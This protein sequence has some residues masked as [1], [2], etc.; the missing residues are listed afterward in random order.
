[1]CIRDRYVTMIPTVWPIERYKSRKRKSVMD[2]QGIAADSVD[3]WTKS[4]IQRY[5]E[6]PGNLEGINLAQFAAWYAPSNLKRRAGNKDIE[7]DEEDGE[8]DTCDDIVAKYRRRDVCRV[9]RF[10]NYDIGDLNNFKREMVT[11]YLPFRNEVRDILDRDKFLQIYDARSEE[12]M[13]CRKEFQNN[14]DIDA[15][16]EEIQALCILEEEQRRDERDSNGVAGPALERRE[17]DAV[18]PN[19]D[20]FDIAQRASNVTAV[21]RR[22]NVMAKQDYCELMHKTNFEQRELIL[23]IIYRIHAR[24]SSEPPIQ[25]FFTGPAG[26]GKTFTL[27]LAM[28]TYNRFSQA[29]NAVNNSYVAC[30]STGKAAVALG[31]VTV[32]SAFR[33]TQSRTIHGMSYDCLLYTSTPNQ[34]AVLP[35]I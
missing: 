2:R 18:A 21:G 4:V 1:M 15:L 28:E 9:I 3:I 19:D 24:E 20:D 10:R 5:E 29:H 6:R 31:G 17:A 35:R 11:L 8:E 16:M 25:I 30:A 32:H 13:N 23:Q 34:R 12:I 7:D 22:S 27:K 33:L 26:C 14:I